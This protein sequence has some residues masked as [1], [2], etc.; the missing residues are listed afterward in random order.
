[1][2]LGATFRRRSQRLVTARRV[3]AGRR[4]WVRS[5]DRRGA[6]V[7]SLGP[8]PQTLDAAD[9]TCQFFLQASRARTR[10]RPAR[11][12]PSRRRPLPSSSKDRRS[13]CCL[14][15][16][17]A[18]LK[19]RCH[20]RRPRGLGAAAN[21]AQRSVPVRHLGLTGGCDERASHL[22]ASLHSAASPVP[23]LDSPCGQCASDRV[24]TVCMSSSMFECL[25]RS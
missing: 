5:Q 4:S 25:C 24:F 15:C 9:Y 6:A 23:S 22:L 17:A 20:R 2:R 19:C 8:R 11:R 12:Y 16:G 13:K 1:M 21:P 18:S 14:D 3:N 10:L 7:E